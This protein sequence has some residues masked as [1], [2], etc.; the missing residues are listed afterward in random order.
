MLT[1]IDDKLEALHFKNGF[2]RMYDGG[3]ESI[4]GIVMAADTA[5]HVIYI[6]FYVHCNADVIIQAS[7][8]QT[9]HAMYIAHADKSGT[10]E[11]LYRFIEMAAIPMPRL[12]TIKRP[13]IPLQESNMYL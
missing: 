3:G 8:A 13:Q 2:E 9:C 4:S 5:S 6:A 10:I 11:A 12:S 7:E 1:S